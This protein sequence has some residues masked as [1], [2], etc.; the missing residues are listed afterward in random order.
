MKL[1]LAGVLCDLDR[2]HPSYSVFKFRQFGCDSYVVYPLVR[3]RDLTV[4]RRYSAYPQACGIY[5]RMSD[6]AAAYPDHQF[7]TLYY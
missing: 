6:L 4:C 2:L 5:L 1:T 3:N 7:S